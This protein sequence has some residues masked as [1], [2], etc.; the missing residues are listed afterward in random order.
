MRPAIRTIEVIECRDCGAP[1]VP[2]EYC[3]CGHYGLT[4]EDRAA[5]EEA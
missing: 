3:D 5:K 4:D 2:G 1:V